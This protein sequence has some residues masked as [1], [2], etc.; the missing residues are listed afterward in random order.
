MK[1]LI[2]NPEIIAAIIG[3]VISLIGI[4]V[5]VYFSYRRTPAAESNQ[6]MMAREI[7]TGRFS[8]GILVVLVLLLLV[9]TGQFYFIFIKPTIV[10]LSETA[11]P[12]VV[13]KE[14][15]VTPEK[16]QVN[17]LKIQSLDSTISELADQKAELT[18]K[19]LNMQNQHR[20]D[21]LKLVKADKTIEK[22]TVSNEKSNSQ[23][24]K[25]E[26]KRL[27]VEDTLSAER[28]EM[29]NLKKQRNSLVDVI[30]FT[31]K[32]AGDCTKGI[33]RKL[34]QLGFPKAEI[35]LLTGINS[36]EIIYFQ[37]Q[38]KKIA[39]ASADSLNKINCLGQ[40]FEVTKQSNKENAHKIF[41]R[42]QN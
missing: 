25:A 16:H 1:Y 15:F 7:S 30:I 27:S 21:S 5:K 2:A 4:L 20:Q 37:P 26:L 28:K 38:T 12:D 29:G 19:I 36:N 35:S 31:N 40:N 33:S 24:T 6:G 32:P 13:T 8:I 3:A 22:L 14:G 23:F 10:S 42:L 39:E 17:L 11:G 34:S 18:T 41:I 9:S